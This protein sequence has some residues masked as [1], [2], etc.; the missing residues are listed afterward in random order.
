MKEFL[1]N[2]ETP[3]RYLPE[4]GDKIQHYKI[5]SLLGEGAFGVV[6]KVEDENGKILALKLIKLWEIDSEKNRKAIL[7]RF[8]REFNISTIDSKYLVKSYSYGKILGNPYFLMHYCTG[9]SLEKWCGTFSSHNNYER[10]A[11]Q[12]LKGLHELH[13]KG[14]VHRDIKPAN[15][16]MQEGSS[17]GNEGY[18]KIADFGIA[19]DKNSKLTVTNIFGKPNQIFGTWAYLS[20]EA[21][22]NVGGKNFKAL[23]N[24]S[25]IF[26]FGVTMFEL[27]TGEYPFPPFRIESQR[28][29]VEYRQHVKNG[30]YANLS[31]QRNKIPQKWQPV[32]ERCLQPDF[33]KKRYQSI[34]DILLSLGYDPGVKS[35]DNLI[36]LP[37]RLALQITYGEELNKL[38]V[39]SGLVKESGNHILTIGRKDEGVFNNI[40]IKE[41]V[42][43]FISRKH[44]TLERWTK[45][46]C[47]RIRDGQWTPEGWQRSKNGLFVNSKEVSVSGVNL[48]AGDIITLGDTII[49]I[50][51]C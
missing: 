24:L 47:W 51:S 8:V 31:L 33:I 27:F 17:S 3:H 50:V 23:N 11:S 13:I 6:Y 19:G 30:N 14:F 25:D 7:A 37:D 49:K 20:P 35:S 15:I 41:T 36:N 10:I 12:I 48:Q 5:V 34:N 21:E 4:A 45:P 22:N 38:Y 2:Y 43:S 28:D 29:L 46:D 1:D 16:L 32:I 18:A 9:G 39:L 42:N 26:S 44:A 40:E